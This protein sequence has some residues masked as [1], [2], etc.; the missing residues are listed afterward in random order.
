VFGT[1]FGELAIIAAILAVPAS[2]AV[3]LV[4]LVWRRR[5]GR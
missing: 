2:G 3:I 5:R 1:S 4:F